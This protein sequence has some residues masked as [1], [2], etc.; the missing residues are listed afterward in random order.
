MWLRSDGRFRPPTGRPRYT[1]PLPNVSARPGDVQAR[2]VTLPHHFLSGLFVSTHP[3]THR[4]QPCS[5]P[6]ESQTLYNAEIKSLHCNSHIIEVLD[7]S[8]CTAIY[9]MTGSPWS[10]HKR[11]CPRCVSGVIN[12]LCYRIPNQQI[13][14]VTSSL[15]V[16]CGPLHCSNYRGIISS[17]ELPHPVSLAVCIHKQGNKNLPLSRAGRP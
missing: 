9:I 12:Y 11:V 17:T 16:L 15:T 14:I 6:Q 4:E 2:S 5:Q 10:Y 13:S 8:L 7:Q 1:D 3:R